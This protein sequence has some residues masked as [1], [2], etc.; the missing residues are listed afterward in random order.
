M[1][2]FVFILLNL[3]LV[4]SEVY[5][6][7]PVHRTFFTCDNTHIASFSDDKSTII[8]DVVTEQQSLKFQEHNVN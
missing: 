1:Y 3:Y 2:E 7:R 8:W 4:Y 6:F 5:F